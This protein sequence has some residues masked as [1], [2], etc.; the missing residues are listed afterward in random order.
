MKADKRFTDTKER[1]FAAALDLFAERGVDATSIRDIASR[2]GISTAGFY[3]HFTSKDALLEAVY[4]HHRKSL[5][6]PRTLRRGDAEALLEKLGPVELL[7]ACTEGFRSAMD[8]PVLEKLGKII[9]MEKSRNRVAAEISYNDRRRLVG[10]MEGLFV[11]LGKKGFIK[12]GNAHVMGRML[13]YALIGIA[14]DNVYHRYMGNQ[15]VEAI[16]KRQN[17]ELRRFMAAVRRG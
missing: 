8:N 13:G 12:P 10:F 6:E 14:E 11:S 5:I 1:L 7:L 17:G 15:G 3:N 4:D 2:V 16:M 9:A